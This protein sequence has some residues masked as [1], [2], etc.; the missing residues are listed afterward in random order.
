[1]SRCRCPF[2]RLFT[3]PLCL[4]AREPITR[5]RASGYEKSISDGVA[6]RCLVIGERAVWCLWYRLPA[7]PS[8]LQL[9]PPTRVMAPTHASQSSD[10]RSVSFQNGSRHSNPIPDVFQCKSQVITRTRISTLHTPV[11]KT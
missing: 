4:E 6:Y 11:M 2:H 8:V 3:P 10:E 7:S 9:Q 5:L 1:M